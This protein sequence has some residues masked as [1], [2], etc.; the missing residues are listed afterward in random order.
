MAEPAVYLL[1]PG[2]HPVTEGNGLFRPK[3]HGWIE[4]IQTEHAA[5]EQHCDK[6]PEPLT[7]RSDNPI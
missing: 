3:A 4:I 6:K 5:N 1:D 7:R 2:M